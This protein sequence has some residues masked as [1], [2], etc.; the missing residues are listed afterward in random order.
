MTHSLLVNDR[1]A[2]KVAG[3]EAAAGDRAGFIQSEGCRESTGLTSAM[4]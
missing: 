3:G 4:A 2:C 1:G